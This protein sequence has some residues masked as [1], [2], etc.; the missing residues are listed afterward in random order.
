MLQTVIPA[1]S[2]E[3]ADCK[4]AVIGWGVFMSYLVIYCLLYIGVVKSTPV[5]LAESFV[6][7]LREW[8][9]WLLLTPLICTGLRAAHA[10]AV[11]HHYWKMLRSYT[12]LGGA[13]LG[14]ALTCRVALDVNDGA[15]LGASVVYFFPK[16]GTALVLIVLAWHLVQKVR[17]V[18]TVE[19][20][21]PC[22]AD[23]RE[24]A[25]RLLVST[26]QHETLI[27]IEDIDVISAAGNYV[28][29]HCKNHVYL[30][31]SP[32][33]QLEDTLPAHQFVR[34][35]R[36]HLVNLDSMRHITRTAAGNGSVILRD[37]LCVP[38]S[39][40]YW[41]ALKQARRVPEV[42]V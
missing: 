39:K 30:L 6:W 33:K 19:Q 15:S 41:A 18:Q 38:I 16:Y 2:I 3:R 10:S 35:H 11:D 14:V 27:R 34:V 7:V 25:D 26:G 8:G 23:P 5:H 1:L 29:I 32:L 36:S 22:S 42:S 13:T 21:P 9:I 12:L 28:D 4:A 24:S 20:T 37:N 40:K 31:R 17:Q